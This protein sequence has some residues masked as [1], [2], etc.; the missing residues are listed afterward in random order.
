M[1]EEQHELKERRRVQNLQAQRRCRWRKK[2][3]HDVILC[4]TSQSEGHTDN[5]VDGFQLSPELNWN[6]LETLSGPTKPG[7]EDFCDDG[8]FRSSS[9][10]LPTPS[11]LSPTD[12]MVPG[13]APSHHKANLGLFLD[14]DLQSA[15]DHS[16]TQPGDSSDRSSWQSRNVPGYTAGTVPYDTVQPYPRPTYPGSEQGKNQVQKRRGP[17]TFGSTQPSTAPARVGDGGTKS[18]CCVAHKARTM[19]SDV[20]KLYKFGLQFGLVAEDDEI[21]E[22]LRFLK[23]RFGEITECCSSAVS[24]SRLG[25]SDLD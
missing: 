9:M 2:T 12:D 14:L 21:Q 11:T 15:P 24:N 13:M 3:S 18:G 20:Q 19:V 23:R 8:D 7:F 17:P 1:D 10:A 6:L 16:L 4:N 22:C 5:A 25:E